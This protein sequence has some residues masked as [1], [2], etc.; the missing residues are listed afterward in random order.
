[1]KIGLCLK[2]TPMLQKIITIKQLKIMKTKFFFL[3]AGLLLL[4]AGCATQK[5]SPSTPFQAERAVVQP[6]IYYDGND[7]PAASSGIV[8]YPG[9]Q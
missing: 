2:T 6:P 8:W 3:L 4:A 1:M 9:E 5:S 7:E